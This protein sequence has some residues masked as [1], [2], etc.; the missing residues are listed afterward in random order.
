MA[1][2]LH[3]MQQ[4]RYGE[5]INAAQDLVTMEPNA[6]PAY[7][8]RG[9]LALYVGDLD[10]ARGDF[11]VAAARAPG[12]AAAQYGAALCALFGRQWDTAR[13]DLAVARR[14]PGLTAAQAA[15]LDTADAYLDFLQGQ[16]VPAPTTEATPADPLRQEMSAMVALRADPTMGAALLTQFLQT[17]SGVPQVREDDG[18]RALFDAQQPLEPSIVEPTLRQSYATQ[19]AAQIAYARR[20]LGSL[21]VVT[22]H[23][24][25][26]APPQAAVVTFSVDGHAAA[27]L[28]SAPFTFDWD[29]TQVVNGR[30]TVTIE[31]DDGAGRVLSVRTRTVEV[32]NDHPQVADDGRGDFTAAD[33]SAAE[34]QLW[35]LLRLRP[36]RKAAQWALADQLA[37][38]GDRAGADAHRLVAAALDPNYRDS[39][40]YAALSFGHAL[41]VALS[42]TFRVAS[43]KAVG[44]WRGDAALKQVALTFDDG[45]NPQK[46]PALLDALDQVGAPV[47][48]FVVG[49][50]AGENPHL[51]RRMARMGDDVENHSYTHPNMD[52]VD[53]I[54]AEEE[55]LRNCVV[56]QALTGRAPRFF[57]PP[58]GNGGLAVGALAR[59]YG[60]TETFWSLDAIG[61]EYAG[62]PTALVHFVLAHVHPGSIVLM[63]DAPDATIAA[64]PALVAGLRAQGYQLVTMTQMAQSGRMSEAGAQSGHE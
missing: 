36:G 30:H 46:T 52:Q 42:G 40:R 15:D 45:P 44:L 4:A 7:E 28:N 5:A 3:L 43:T 57:R 59:R 48:F 14:T 54:V 20:R 18:V 49:A 56:V 61:M 9:T 22:G 64:I 47:T 35:D 58:G 60:L 6:A 8:V 41:P 27:M 24:R 21:A 25:L 11:G 51:I 16:P 37:V 32:R 29:T 2:V 38:R 10:R 50:R 1:W 23:V 55:L 39:R 12:D 13:A 63:H 19:I 33:V 53:P 34:P 62:S 26:M 31:T 17:P